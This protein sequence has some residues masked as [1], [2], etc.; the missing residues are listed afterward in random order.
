MK[1]S[2]TY[3]D[4]QSLFK[5]NLELASTFTQIADENLTL[6]PDPSSWSAGEIVEHIVR[7]NEIYLRY[8]ER[9]LKAGPLPKVQNKEFK[10][11]F[12]FGIIINRLRPPYTLKMKTISPMQPGDN[13]SEHYRSYI[14]KL[15]QSNQ[16]IVDIIA[17]AAEQNLDLNKIKGKN[18]IFKIKMTVIEFLLMFEAHQQRHFWQAEQTLEKITG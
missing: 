14:D 7:F 5:Q 1:K 9:A 10:P 17:G 13:N 2:F 15:I 6:K 18:S 8:I 4:L 3:P 12:I 11:R 16:N